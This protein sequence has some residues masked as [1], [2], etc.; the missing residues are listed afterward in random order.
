MNLKSKIGGMVLAV[1]LMGAVNSCA[2]MAAHY[3][4][5][6]VDKFVDQNLI[7]SL[8][9]KD[10]MLFWVSEYS[11]DDRTWK[12]KEF[13]GLLNITQRKQANVSLFVKEAIKKRFPNAAF[14]SDADKA[15][16]RVKIKRLREYSGWRW[17]NI[18]LKAAINDKEAVIDERFY[19]KDS[20]WTEE[21]FGNAIKKL[22]SILAAK[23]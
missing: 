15:N 16:V 5:E 17:A 9:E 21:E 18:E 1:V 20:N 2:P 19:I 11:H 6:S 10:A 8:V 14:V 4:M 3:H 13:Y 23:I 22:A 7:N 12:F